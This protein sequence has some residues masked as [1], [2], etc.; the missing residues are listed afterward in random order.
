[1]WYWMSSNDT[2]SG[3]S[4][5]RRC[6]TSF[7]VFMASIVASADGE[8]VQPRL[9][10]CRAKEEDGQ[11]AEAEEDAEGDGELHP[12]VVA[13][14]ERD[15]AYGAADRCDQEDRQQRL[16]AHDRTNHRKHLHVAE[17]HSF[18]VGEE[19]VRERDRQEHAGADDGAEQ[20]VDQGVR[21]NE[22]A[23]ELL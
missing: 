10:E 16:G 18:D 6:T 21:E 13:H 20:G 3:S 19:L 2:P 11:C 15:G 5:S 8:R 7:G 4:E 14:G 17:A 22:A 9:P 12:F 23:R 1:M